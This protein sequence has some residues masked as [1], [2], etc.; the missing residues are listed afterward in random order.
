LQMGNIDYENYHLQKRLLNV[1]P[2]VPQVGP[3]RQPQRP[4]R[5]T[6]TLSF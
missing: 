6:V 4:Y 2:T 1:K 5:L 3:A